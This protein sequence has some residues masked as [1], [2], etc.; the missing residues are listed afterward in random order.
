MFLHGL[1]FDRRMWDP[2]LD[3]LPS[4]HRAIAFDL[5]G[6]GGSATLPRP[7]LAAV[8]EAVHAAALD[9]GLDAPIVV[10]H[11]NGGRLATIYAAAHPAAAVV[12]VDAPMRLEPFAELLCS[13]RG[14][15]AGDRFAEAWAIFQDSWH[16]E[17]LPAEARALLRAGDRPGDD[18]LRQ[19]VLSYHADVLERPLDEVMRERDAGLDRL[20]A[21]GTPYLAL[22]SCRVDPCDAAWLNERMPQAEILVWPVGHHFPHLTHP[23]R[24]AVLLTGLAQAVQLAQHTINAESEQ[25]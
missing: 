16:M 1:T 9:L 11:S 22:S 23:A 10:G 21:A 2:V 3:A 19:L 13:L 20:R 17:L 6:H 14:E 25:T 7:G 24:L 18:V 4:G 12:T 5:P 8:A 15:L